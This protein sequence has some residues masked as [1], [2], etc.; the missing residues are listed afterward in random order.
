MTSIYIAPSRV[1]LMSLP[2]AIAVRLVIT[3]TSWWIST[4]I[5]VRLNDQAN[6]YDI[7]AIIKLNIFNVFNYNL[8]LTL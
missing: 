5:C 3:I 7:F 8:S 2:K 4:S 6:I 1:Q